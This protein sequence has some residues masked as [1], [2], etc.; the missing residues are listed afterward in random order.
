[1]ALS[2]VNSDIDINLSKNK[3]TDDISLVKDA[4]AV[5][6]SLIN[7][8]LTIP[9]EKPFSRNFGTKINDMLFENFTEMDVAF[10]EKNIAAN[11]ARYEPRA[12]LEYIDIDTDL[13]DNNQV[14][15]NIFFVILTG[16]E[17]DVTHDSIRIGL[18]KVR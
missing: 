13:I 16:A 18:N 2:T 14:S 12:A 1:M 9:G 5:R 3:F 11:F 7:L 4:Y 8:I 6:Q 15:I 10:L 17:A